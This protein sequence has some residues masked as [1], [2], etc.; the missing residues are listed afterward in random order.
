MGPGV[1]MECLESKDGP[2][3]WEDHFIRKLLILK[4]VRYCQMVSWENWYLPQLPKKVC[5][6]FVTVPEI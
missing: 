6:L 5:R 4:L 3:I 1:A 2:T